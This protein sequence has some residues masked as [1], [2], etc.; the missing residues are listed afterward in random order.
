MPMLAVAREGKVVVKFCLFS[1][2]IRRSCFG[3]TELAVDEL[4]VVISP[5]FIPTHSSE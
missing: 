5:Q 3:R 1:F 2:S 4:T